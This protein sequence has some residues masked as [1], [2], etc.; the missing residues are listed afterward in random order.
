MRY[1]FG[2]SGF[3]LGWGGTAGLI[4]GVGTPRFRGYVGL[5][6]TA[7]ETQACPPCAPDPR[8]KDNKIVIWGKIFFDTAKATIKPV[9]Y[10]V[11]DDVVDVLRTHP[12]IRLV[13]VQGHCDWR[14]SDS[15]NL[16]LSQRRTESVRQYLINAGIDGNRLR[17]VGYGESQPIASNDTVEGMSQNRRVEFVIIESSAGYTTTP[18]SSDSSRNTY[19]P[20]HEIRNG[21]TVGATPQAVSQVQAPEASPVAV[22]PEPVRP[23]Y[24]SQVVNQERAT[25]V[26]RT[27]KIQLGV[28][29]PVVP[30]MQPEVASPS[31]DVV[32]TPQMQQT[33]L[34]RV[35]SA[36]QVEDPNDTFLDQEVIE[37]T[38]LPENDTE[39]N[40]DL[41]PESV[42]AP[43]Q[44]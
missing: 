8:I 26:P 21:V 1:F 33:G 19:A 41:V 15:Y 16:G 35:G 4:E 2:D 6:W 7:P 38:T 28:P 23:L 31:Q 3:A 11:L 14:G 17:A 40:P 13:E 24:P 32:T 25:A 9:S 22:I 5:T 37:E 18:N 36:K 27:A 30:I 43:S 20:I 12:E 29:M 10:P 34:E 42:P 44:N 39:T